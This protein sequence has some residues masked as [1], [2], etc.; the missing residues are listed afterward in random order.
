[1][2][3]HPFRVFCVTDPRLQATQRDCAVSRSSLWAAPVPGTRRSWPYCDNYDARVSATW[4]H[5]CYLPDIGWPSPL[6]FLLP[7]MPTHPLAH[8]SLFLLSQNAFPIP[9]P[10]NKTQRKMKQRR[11]AH[12]MGAC[13]RMWL[14]LREG[15]V[16]L[17]ASCGLG[18]LLPCEGAAS[19]SSC[20]LRPRNQS[21]R[22]L[23][24]CFIFS[25]VR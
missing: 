14:A 19:A 16:W 17:G 7:G 12:T 10:P 25:K 4:S 13:T 24:F 18:L 15:S 8:D 9:W 2:L 1:M 5:L 6:L 11:W 22:G 3:K 20:C 21:G 23:L